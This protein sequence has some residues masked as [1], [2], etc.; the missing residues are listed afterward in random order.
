MNLF[1]D[2]NIF[3]SFFHLSNDDLEEIHKLTILLEKGNVKLWLTKQVKDEF[4][5]NRENKIFDAV[6]KL[7]EQKSKPQF[8][9]ICKD[10]DEYPILR[11]LQKE[12]DQK[13]AILIKK[14]NEDILARTLKA[15]EKIAELFSKA[16]LIATTDKLVFNARLRMN[17]GNPPGKNGSLGDAINW[18][19]LLESVP[20]SEK[21][22]LIADDKD[23]FSVLDEN[24]LKDFLNDEWVEKKKS[25]I[26]FY[27]RLSQFFKEHYPEIKLASE[28][29][30]EL[31]IRSLAES[32]AFATTHSAIARLNKYTEFSKTQANE[33]AQIAISNSQ[34]SWILCDS[35]VYEFYMPFFTNHEKIID[36]ELKDELLEALTVCKKAEADDSV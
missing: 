13:L 16:N 11:G 26:V 32:G 23:Y 34:I 28:L 6:K 29:E 25:E 20:L 1:I 35:D 30:K 31:A 4:F 5:R 3:L 7:N 33:I 17:V 21:M 10:Y 9:Q 36:P 15:D 27:R 12:F 18:E 19:A 24:K 2:T 22:Y 14:V 8:P